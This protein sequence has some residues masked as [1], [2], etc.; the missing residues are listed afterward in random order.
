[1]SFL[2]LVTDQLNLR[3]AWEKVR[4]ASTPG[5]AWIDEIELGR[6][7]IELERNLQSIATEMRNGSYR[8]RPLRPM[9]FP[10]NSKKDGEPQVRQYFNVAVRDQVAWTAVVNVIGSYLDPLMPAWSYGNRLFRSIWVDTDDD[11]IRSRKIGRY[12]HSSGRIYLSFGQSWPIFRRH[13]FLATSAMTAEVGTST[14]NQLTEEDA[15]ERDLQERLKEEHRCPFVLKQYWADRKP[16]AGKENLFWCSLDLE[17]FYPSIKLDS[18]RLNIVEFLPDDIKTEAAKLID[19]MI[20]FKVDTNTDRWSKEELAAIGL[21]DRQRFFKFIPTGLYIAGFLAN[22]GLLKVDLEVAE[23]LKTR[24]VSHFRFVDDHVILAY[25]FEDLV[26]WIDEYLSLLADS[27]TGAKVNYDKMEPEALAKYFSSRKK[28]RKR[29]SADLDAAAKA[30]KLNP[31]F[32]TPLMTKTLAL[33][34]AIAR[35]DLDLLEESELV[36]LTD[37]LEHMLLVELPEAEIP[38]KTRLSFAATKLMRLAECRLSNNARLAE[39]GCR[40]QALDAELADKKLSPER[41]ET[42]KEANTEIHKL[43]NAQHAQLNREVG[44]AFGLLRKVLQERPD[45][46]RLWTRAIQMCRQTGVKGL[47][48]IFED[49]NRVANELNNTLAAEY[50]LANTLALLGSEVV[51]AARLVADPDAAEWRRRAAHAFLADISAAAL[52]KPLASKR[53]WFLQNSWEQFCFGLFC[54]DVIAKSSL[55]KEDGYR[56]KLPAELIADG[57]R[58]LTSATVKGHRQGLAWWGARSSLRELSSRAPSWVVEIG[59]RLPSDSES[60]AFWR[61][62]PFDVPTDILLDMPNDRSHSQRVAQMSGWWYDAL[63]TKLKIAPRLLAKGRFPEIA[64]ALR[65]LQSASNSRFV[66]LHEW[67]IEIQRICEKDASDPRASEWTALEIVRQIGMRITESQTFDI[68]Y[69]AKQNTNRSRPLCLH[70]ANFRVPRKW[71]KLQSPT[72]SE[73][74]STIQ[75]D[76]IMAQVDKVPEDLHVAD[77]RYTPVSSQANA[78]FDSVNPVRGLGLLLYGLLRHDFSLPTVW[79]G[80]GHADVLGL[81]PRRLLKDMTCSSLTLGVL[82]ACLQP[83][84]MENLFFRI[85]IILGESLNDDSL[86]DPIPLLTAE[87]VCRAIEKCKALLEENQLSTINHRARQLTPISILQLTNPDWTKAFGDLQEG[88]GTDEH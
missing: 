72:W 86:H 78:L 71:L 43:L 14:S 24:N 58:F 48:D 54:A 51:I 64:N 47:K 70:P 16:E 22:V 81:L 29:L 79:N 45:R 73:W 69:V 52:K 26:R 6:F 61:F 80:P 15:E 63:S 1:M 11:G 44:R 12:R 59:R 30:C 55:A 27:K 10:K 84:A 2:E 68:N 20:R 23:R 60:Y 67:C 35:T 36:A 87:E 75:P 25:S 57:A 19:S 82:Q 76:K 53:R 37:Q 83:R 50:L 7:E 85:R 66:P 32:P 33:V 62:F 40:R 21:K 4:R 56:F 77:S 34:S 3:W 5:D 28:S 9:A 65:N 46:V 38:E 42:L 39:L 8:L 88:G 31:Q 74:V 49:I 41:R 18:I 13:V 17:K